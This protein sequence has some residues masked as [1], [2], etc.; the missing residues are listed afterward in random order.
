MFNIIA[1]NWNAIDL[2]NHVSSFQRLII[3]T[4]KKK[5]FQQHVWSANLV[6]FC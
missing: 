3:V 6:D 5:K 2:Q 4:E 1:C